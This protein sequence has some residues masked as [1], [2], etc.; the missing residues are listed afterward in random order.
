MFRNKEVRVFLRGQAKESFLELK[1]RTDKESLILVRSIERKI[2]ILKSNPQFG[3]PI[4]KE[5]I[6]EKFL[7]QN[8]HN[9]YRLELSNFWRML[10]TIEGDKVEIFVFVLSIS[11]HKEYDQL[12]G[13][14]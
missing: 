4:K 11:D 3:D 9:L 12:L 8:I 1:K 14:K 6:P 7:Q 13:Y 2:E 10:Y 5:L